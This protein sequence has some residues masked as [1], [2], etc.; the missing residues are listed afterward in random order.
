MLS[1]LNVRGS[2]PPEGIKGATNATQVNLEG[3]GKDL[4]VVALADMTLYRLTGLQ[5]DTTHF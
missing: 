4:A 5:G 1:I 3:V 2:W